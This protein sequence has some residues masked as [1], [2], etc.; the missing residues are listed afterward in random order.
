MNNRLLI[1]NWT[2][3]ELTSL[4]FEGPSNGSSEEIIIDNPAQPHRLNTVPTF[5]VQLRSLLQLLTHIVLRDGLIVDSS[6]TDGW[7][8]ED[9]PLRELQT[10]SLVEA[11][12]FARMAPKLKEPRD[13]I[14]NDLCVTD[15][16][17]EAQRQ[18]QFWWTR[19]R[20]TKDPYLSQVM[21]GGAGMLARSHVLETPYTG[22]PMRQ[23]LMAQT[24]LFIARR[25]AAAEILD[26]LQTE[27]TKLIQ[28]CGDGASVR[29]YATFDVPPF[30]IE[31]IMNSNT[32]KDLIPVAL[33]LREKY[34]RLRKLITEYEIALETEDIKT[35]LKHRKRLNSVANS[36]NEFGKR[37]SG[38]S[39]NFSVSLSWLSMSWS[40]NPVDKILNK[41]G[42]RAI[43]GR[44]LVSPQGEQGIKKLLRMF[45]EEN[46]RLGLEASKHLLSGPKMAA[47]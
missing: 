17:R 38:G 13:V 2:L 41:F 45:S 7:N 37:E 24:P 36:I 9:S 11:H 8:F 40:T 15:S 32:V 29:R 25:D 19:Y 33:Q 27:R 16:L 4:L 20:K 3:E 39:T 47:N 6:F 34:S 31:V 5:V 44:L 43:L 46:S 42:V 21:W 28:A 12:P 26:F 23:K 18:N 30:A 14:L 35:L 1:D 22:H 10:F